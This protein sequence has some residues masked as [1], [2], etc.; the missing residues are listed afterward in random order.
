MTESNIH[1]VGELAA[2]LPSRNRPW[3]L[4]PSL[5]QLNVYILFV[6][7]SATGM[8]F[9]GSMMNGL[10]SLDTWVGYFNNPSSALLGVTNAALNLGPVRALYSPNEPIDSDPSP[11]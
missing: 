7:L 4:T 5:L 10:Q 11:R 9:D 3:Y 2:V 6:C 1:S 8:G